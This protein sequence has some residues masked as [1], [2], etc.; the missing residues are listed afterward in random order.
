MDN[1]Q[2]RPALNPVLRIRRYP[3]P[4]S[5]LGGGKGRDSIIQSRLE[6]QQGT[7]GDQARE[8]YLR[9]ETFPAFAGKAL[10]AVQMFEDS[11]AP[12]H[13][14]DD[15]F[16]PE[17]GCRLVAPF[18]EGYLVEATPERFEELVSGIQ[19]PRTVRQE[20]DISR[21]ASLSVLDGQDWLDGRSIVDLWAASVA[22][23]EGRLLCLWLSPLHDTSARDALLSKLEAF[24]IGRTLLLRPSTTMP[25]NRSDDETFIP[26]LGQ[27]SH[28]SILESL[29]RAYRKDGVARVTVMVPDK[30]SLLHVV[31]SGITVRIDPI[32]PVKSTSPGTGPEPRRPLQLE[33]APTVAVVDGGLH[34][35][36]YR[37][38]ETWRATPL[39]RDS[40]ANRIHGNQITSLCVHGYAWNNNR[41]LPA[42]EC[43]IGTAQAIPVESSMVTIRGSE[44]AAYI[45]KVAGQ[46]PETRVWNLS[47]N[48]TGAIPSN[49]KVSLWGD[50][51]RIVAR[52]H[53]IL[54]VISIGNVDHYNADRPSPPADCEAAI[55]VGGREA[56]PNGDLRQRPCAICLQ[57][58]GPL[59]ML[60]PDVS[61]YSKLRVLGGGIG[62]GSSYAAPLVSSLAAHSFAKL[63]DPSPDLVKALL[64]NAAERDAHDP[65]LGWGTPYHVHMP[66][67]CAPGAV[68]MIWRA[69]LQP[70]LA[71]YWND[72]PIPPE[73]L[74]KGKLYGKVRLT[75]ILNPLVSPHG[76]ANYFASRLQ[77][78]LQYIPKIGQA[79]QG[80]LQPIREETIPN[81]SRRNE[82]LKWHPVRHHV[83]DFSNGGGRQVAYDNF[84]LYARIYT[85]DFYQVGL[86]ASNE[87]DPQE[88]AFV[89]TLLSGESHDSIYDSMV[90]RLGTFV[91]SAVIEQDV[92][93]TVEV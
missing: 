74:R 93:Q 86:D 16:S 36:S 9:R 28:D 92:E 45:D 78:S 49:V 63:K 25:I 48:E 58:P 43:R 66:W 22:Y 18:R 89:L 64:I 2:S 90:Q 83:A 61:W 59:G 33:G 42:L 60:K 13:T 44:V 87:S 19:N 82:L 52:K 21:V 6:Q 51:L 71:Y 32:L 57:G 37:S 40:D 56:D 10:V 15:L 70:K 24:I 29:M 77:T 54:I 91:E 39:V 68:T 47:A 62:T 53:R 8:L 3:E 17:F 14:P 88:V 30:A 50:D 75:A 20:A 23:K 67:V 41:T 72:L 81:D 69:L 4:A 27:P 1:D 38:A 55:V 46:H 65:K 73:L 76:G 79:W 31:S 80:L 35:S 85:R 84:R 5:T 7:L 34:A 11:F 26:S 12:S